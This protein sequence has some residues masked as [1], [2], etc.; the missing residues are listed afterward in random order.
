MQLSTTK[1]EDE[2]VEIMARAICAGEDFYLRAIGI[3]HPWEELDSPLQEQYRN[4]A[5]SALQALLAV[6][7][8][9][10]DG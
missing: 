3:D 8:V 5:R 1:T 9:T 7:D 2:L 4:E 10:S 6:T